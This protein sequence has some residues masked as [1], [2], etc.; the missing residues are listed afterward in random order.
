M[1]STDST[2]YQWFFVFQLPLEKQA[3]NPSSLAFLSDEFN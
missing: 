2:V 3:S 1:D